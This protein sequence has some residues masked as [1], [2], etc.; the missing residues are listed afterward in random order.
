MQLDERMSAF[1]H[2]GT[3]SAG[4]EEND[5]YGISGLEGVHV[6]PGGSVPE[7]YSEYGTLDIVTLPTDTA[8]LPKN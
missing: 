3:T 6:V 1:V 2:K 5:E 4:N 8:P 7:V